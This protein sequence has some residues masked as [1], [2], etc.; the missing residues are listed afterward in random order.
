MPSKMTNAYREYEGGSIIVSDQ[1]RK[2]VTESRR[3]RQK[4]AR[5]ERRYR[6]LRATWSFYPPSL[7]TI[8]LHMEVGPLPAGLL[9]SV[10]YDIGCFI[11]RN[12]LGTIF[13][14]NVETDATMD[15]TVEDLFPEEAVKADG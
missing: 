12:R 13:E 5:I 10:P 14:S 1:Y 4:N 6:K 8:R 3:A 11:L 2:G 15:G 7:M 9:L